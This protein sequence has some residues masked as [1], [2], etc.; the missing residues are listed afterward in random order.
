M[1]K[2]TITSTV[3]IKEELLTTYATTMDEELG[4]KRQKLSFRKVKI[5]K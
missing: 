3:G 4:I 1:K 2:N 5:K